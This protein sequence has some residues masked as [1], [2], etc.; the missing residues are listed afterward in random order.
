[1]MAR[2]VKTPG[3]LAWPAAAALLLLAASAPA[4]AQ[5]Q[6]MAMPDPSQMSGVPLPSGDLAN[7]EVTIRVVRGS[8]ANN[9]TGQAVELHGGPEVLTQT[10]D[11]N[12]RAQ[13]FGVAPGTMVHGV[14]VVDGTRLESQAF[15]VPAQGGVRVMLVAPDAAMDARA[16]EDAKLAAA[17][18]VAGMVVIGAQSQFIVELED[19]ILQVYYLLQIANN[20]RTPVEPPEPL[21]FTLPAG[22]RGATILEG[23]SPLARA[24]GSRVVVNGPFPPGPTVV[25]AAYELPYDGSQVT[26]AQP[27]PAQL[28]QLSLVVEKVG[29]MHVES[30][31]MA[32]H[33]DMPADGKTYLVGNGPA[34]AAGQALTFTVTGL[35]YRATWP[36]TLALVLAVGILGGGVWVAMSPAADTGVVDKRRKTLQGRR[37]RLFADLVR[38]EEQ[39]RAGQVD[40]QRY[41][42]RRRELVDQ[43]ERIYAD[44]DEGLAA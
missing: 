5:G 1:M 10:T 12:G 35:P 11:E 18:A 33:G 36:R 26:I 17:P 29:A 34:I 20:A 3:R 2:R 19:D 22:A 41:A 24:E 7:G 25:Q 13:F 37:D 30:A 39:H 43:L 40:A 21:V 9:I 8:V 4:A 14:A 28:E 42:T 44:L 32:S 23:S 15:P 27:L 38:L 31:Q 6:G 16:A